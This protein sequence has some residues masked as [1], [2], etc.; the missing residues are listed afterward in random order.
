[1]SF[2]VE[3]GCFYSAGC[4]ITAEKQLFGWFRPTDREITA[5]KLLI[6]RIWFA[7]CEITAEKQLIR[8]DLVRGA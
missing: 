4:E 1:V 3:K 8:P 2:D 7:E 5:K 6:S